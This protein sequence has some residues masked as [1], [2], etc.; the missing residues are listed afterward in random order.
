MRRSR[1]HFM[2]TFVA[3]VALAT[4]SVIL[5]NALSA[6]KLD[7]DAIMAALEAY[8]EPS[9]NDLDALREGLAELA[10]DLNRVV[11]AYSAVELSTMSAEEVKAQADELV[12]LRDCLPRIEKL[13]DNI[14]TRID[15][16]EQMEGVTTAAD[17][18]HRGGRAQLIDRLHE[19]HAATAEA[20]VNALRRAGIGAAP[21][22]V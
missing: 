9:W 22:G 1:W 3:L 16:L 10:A 20:L 2:R 15:A 19:E 18:A 6:Q 4:P 21:E 8:V 12:M 11:P 7:C 5:P 17:P 13:L 14:R